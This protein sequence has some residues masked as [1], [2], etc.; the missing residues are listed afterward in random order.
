MKLTEAIAERVKD[1][2]EKKNWKQYDLFKNGG[3]PRSTIS[4]VVNQN[5]KRVSVDT[6]YQICS[7]FGI[8]LSEFFDDKFF[9]DI[10]DWLLVLIGERNF[11]FENCIILISERVLKETKESL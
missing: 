10:E 1:L 2:L 8:T 11:L 7:T 5:K 6:I 3:I 4:N 9:S